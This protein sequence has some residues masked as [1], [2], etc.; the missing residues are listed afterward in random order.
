M[1]HDSWL[2]VLDF[3]GQSTASIKGGVI[4]SGL[5]GAVRG[6]PFRCEEH[7]VLMGDR[8]SNSC[9]GIPFLFIFC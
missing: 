2:P 5:S 1:L 4:D 3:S 7:A 8:D 9:A 6:V